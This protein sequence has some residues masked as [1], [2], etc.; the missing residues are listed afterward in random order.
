MNASADWGDLY[1]FV[2]H[3][4]AEARRRGVDLLVVDVRFK[5]LSCIC[6]AVR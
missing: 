4:K 6:R 5:S 3:L 1:S 2:H